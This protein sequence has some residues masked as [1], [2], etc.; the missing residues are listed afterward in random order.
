MQTIYFDNAATS[1]PKPQSVTQAITSFLE[2]SGG[3]P[4]RSG[5]RLALQAGEIVLECRE[6]LAE[7]FGIINPMQTIFTMNATMALNLAIQGELTQNDHV[8]ITSFEHNSVAR[9]LH[10]LKIN[11][12]IDYSIWNIDA[13]S[14]PDLNKLSDLIKTNTR[15]II[16]NHSSNVNGQILPLSEIGRFCREKGVLFLVDAAQS[17]GAAVIDMQF[18]SIDFLAIAGHKGLFGPPGTGAL[19][20]GDK[21]DPKIIKPLYMGGTGSLSTDINQ[22]DFLPDR[23]ESGT[24]NGCGIAGLSAGLT[25]LQHIGLNN[26]IQHK[27]LLA[28]YFL[29]KSSKLLDDKIIHFSNRNL[30]NSGISAFN[31]K[32][33]DPSVIGNILSDDYS[34]MCRTGL[35]CAPLAHQSLKTYPIGC[36]RFSYSYTNT[37]NQIDMAINSLAEIL[38]CSD[39]L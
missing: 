38:T 13:D 8:I 19:L 2:N 21:I 5:H 10:T 7:M 24:P 9:P 27:Q 22:P 1:W 25:Y 30:P 35:H 11:G 39:S 33:C 32:N 18:D 15:M 28:S 37:I 20:I 16:I 12:L 26:V 3:N 23:L 4:G 31:L 14:Q 36:V 34:I 17:A 29:E 6:Q